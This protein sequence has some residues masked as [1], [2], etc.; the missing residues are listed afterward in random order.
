MLIDKVV[1]LINLYGGIKLVLDKF[2]IFVNVYFGEKGIIFF[3]V[4]YGNVVG[5]RGFVI[6][7]FK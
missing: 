1:N 2:F 3:V 4:R 6:L 5:S 7:F